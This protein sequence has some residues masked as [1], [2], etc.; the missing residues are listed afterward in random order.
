MY[1]HYQKW[2]K[3]VYWQLVLQQLLSQYKYLLDLS[4]FN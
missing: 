4:T 3:A 1:H 2:C